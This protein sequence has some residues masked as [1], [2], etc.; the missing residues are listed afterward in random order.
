M[1]FENGGVSRVESAVVRGIDALPVAV[2]ATV[3]RGRLPGLVLRGVPD[4]RALELR[5]QVRCAIRASGLEVPA[6]RVEVSAE[7]ALPASCDAACLALPIAAS[8]LELTGQVPELAPGLLLFG[9]LGIDGAVVDAAGAV[10]AQALAASLRMEPVLPLGSELSP[11][12]PG[13]RA[14]GCL[15]ELA[16][17]PCVTAPGRV[18]DESDAT[19]SGGAERAPEAARVAVALRQRRNVVLV[20]PRESTIRLA[21]ACR[22]AMP[23]VGPEARLV[24]ERAI[25]AAHLTGDGLAGAA[26]PWREV[27]PLDPL[28]SIIG[29]GRPVRPGAATLAHGGALVIRDAESLSEGALSAL[30]RAARDRR[31]DIVR[32]DGL[33]A[34]PADVSVIAC[35]S[36]CPCGHRGDRERECAC[37]PRRV[38]LHQRR[39][40]RVAEALGAEVVPVG[41]GQIR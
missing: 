8:V 19:E 34:M 15:G 12:L 36:P 29:G 33:Y 5:S 37:P 20:G 6:A 41:A 27:G 40:A 1:L 22:R 26:R 9:G 17:L 11:S 30:A 25:S 38:E 4:G 13:A 2:T 14:V 7:P 10:C 39:V 21:R 28:A 23:R 31:V 3:E 18:G 24:V 35:A 16:D 32:T